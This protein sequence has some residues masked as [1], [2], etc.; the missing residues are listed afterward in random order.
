MVASTRVVGR[1]DE[2][3]TVTDRLGRAA[4]G[5]P[6]AVVVAGDAGIG[7]TRFVREVAARARGDGWTVLA[8]ACVELSEGAAMLAPVAQVLRQLGRDRGD[9]KLAALLEG[10]AL[11]LARLVPELAIDTAG[12]EAGSAAQVL[13]S[14]HRLLRRLGDEAPV[15][16]VLED[17]HWADVTTRDLL[18]HLSSRLYDERLLVL[19]TVRTDDLDR[20]HPLRPVL[21]EVVRRPE[22]VR[23]DLGPLELGALA[24]HLARSTGNPDGRDM[25]AIAERAGGNPFFAEEMAEVGADGGLPPSLEEVLSLRLERLPLDAQ[26]LLGEAAVLGANIDPTLL[27]SVTSLHRAA[28]RSALRSALDD[29]VLLVDGAAYAFR[30]A[31]LREVALEGLLPEE[32]VAAHAAAAAA[33]EAAPDLAAAGRAGAQGQVAHH[34][35]EAGEPSRCLVASV[36]AAREAENAFAGA[37]ALRHLRRAIELWEVADDPRALTGTTRGALLLAATRVAWELDAPDVRELGVAAIREADAARDPRA[38]AEASLLQTLVLIRFGHVHEAL[39]VATRELARHDE[40]GSAA[41]A[42][43][44]VAHGAAVTRASEGF[45]GAWDLD[46]IATDFDVALAAARAAG[47]V[48]VEATVLTAD[49][50][51]IGLYLADRASRAAAALAALAA[52]G[53]AGAITPGL[54]TYWAAQQA[55]LTGHHDE[56]ESAVARWQATAGPSTDTQSLWWLIMSSIAIHAHA[57]AGHLDRAVARVDEL[58]LRDFRGRHHATMW[59]VWAAG[60]TLRW[61]GRLTEALERA[62]LAFTAAT[63]GYRRLWYA[64]E[65][66]ASRAAIG[67]APRELI[68]ASASTTGDAPVDRAWPWAMARLV[69]AV[70]TA[71]DNRPLDT[72]LLTIVDGWVRRLVRYV[73]WLRDDAPIR[74][75]AEACLRRTQAQRAV[76]AGSPDPA[77]WDPVVTHFETQ[78]SPS[79]AAIARLRRAT[80]CAAADSASSPACERDVLTAWRGFVEMGM[81]APRKESEGLARGLRIRL[82]GVD[83]G[84]H[85]LQVLPDLTGRE[86]EVLALVAR[87][88]SNKQVGEHLFISPKTVSVH[89]SNTMRKLD[90]ESRTQAVLVAHGAGLAPDGGRDT[91][92][93]L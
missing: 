62:E 83:D 15:L 76:L 51:T 30:H 38:R 55:Y 86:R 67:A 53:R 1:D 57:W 68:I 70:A 29:G 7:K 61:S 39:D 90:V 26:R 46:D 5:A 9:D 48:D 64:A 12:L 79:Y 24:A 89:L 84:N 8:G 10:P 13:V 34:W 27:S 14:F 11:R 88:W 60:D 16:L 63:A 75:W 71:A 78:G 73:G 56:L 17:L 69:D 25:R 77:L 93:R 32:R 20:R 92:G 22:V 50:E 37:V 49:I 87:G 74:S 85:D 45:E 36:L 41:R 82:P 44:L 66:A 59:A 91:S 52:T 35:W 3:S 40:E 31:L 47:D 2:L 80:A 54:A 72:D 23:V 58:D 43:A 81:T 4:E 6:G 65:L 42:L 33:L 18:L 28:V 19:A 21:A